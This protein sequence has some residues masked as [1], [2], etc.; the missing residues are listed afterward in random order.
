[1]PEIFAWKNRLRKNVATRSSRWWPSAILL[2][3]CSSANEYSAP[4][5]R[6]EPSEHKVLPSGTPR[7]TNESVS[8][9]RIRESTPRNSK[10]TDRTHSGKAGCFWARCREHGEEGSGERE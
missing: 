6:R 9:S 8:G 2:N 3:P 10:Y 5:R 4:R 1:M 7:V